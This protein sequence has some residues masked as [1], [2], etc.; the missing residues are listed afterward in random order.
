[1]DERSTTPVLVAS[2]GASGQ[3][4][5]GAD[6]CLGKPLDVPVLEAAVAAMCRRQASLAPSDSGR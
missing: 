6:L 1:V 4:P 2:A 3:L 5:A